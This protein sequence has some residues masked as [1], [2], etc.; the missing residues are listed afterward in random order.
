[1]PSIAAF[2]QTSICAL[3]CKLLQIITQ[4]C[5]SSRHKFLWESEKK[6][7]IVGVI[8]Q[9]SNSVFLLSHFL[10]F[11]CSTAPPSLEYFS[12]AW[13]YLLKLLKMYFKGVKSPLWAGTQ[14][15]CSRSISWTSRHAR[16][17]LV[18]VIDIQMLN[19]DYRMINRDQCKSQMSLTILLKLNG[20]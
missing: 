20:L 16:L 18:R 14:S 3:S 13:I 2:L 11:S 5:Y 15:A 8:F 10:L 4:L 17:S 19:K 7:K 1:M 6:A 9:I 12:P